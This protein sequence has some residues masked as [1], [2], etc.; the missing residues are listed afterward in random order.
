[1]KHNVR[2]AQLSNFITY[3][4]YRRQCLT[5][6]ENVIQIDNLPK[7]IDQA[8]FNKMLVNKGS[9]AFFYDEVLGVLALP[10]INMGGLDL[11]GR[12]ANK[13][14]VIGQNGY[15][16]ILNRGEYYIMYDNNGMYPIYLDVLQYA[17]R[18][19]LYT[20][21]IDINIEQQQTS[22]FWK[23]PNGKEK[24]LTDLLQ[25]VDSKVNTIVT[26]DD[27][28]LDDT[29]LVMS[30]APY[31]ADKVNIEKEK[32]WAEFLR[33]IGVANNSYQKKERNIRDEIVTSQGGTIASRFSRYDPRAN[34]VEIINEM[35]GEYLEKP[36]EVSY[37]DGLPTTIITNDYLSDIKEVDNDVL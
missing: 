14:Q 19:A 35:F 12:P 22:R 1:M 21:T 24:S 9:I 5:L 16:K 31:I 25:H 26:Y 11:Y 2:Q 8:Y 34:G 37:Y 18:L 10:Y 13:I 15:N 28:D 20:R 4:M 36:L 33:F 3:N 30:P 7:M 32:L 27:L 6:A 17:E 29:T 23:C